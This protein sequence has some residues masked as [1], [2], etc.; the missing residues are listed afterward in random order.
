MS[1][2]AK[3]ADRKGLYS[4][5]SRVGLVRVGEEGREERDGLL[6]Y[7]QGRKGGRG[8]GEKKS[9]MSR[10]GGR[11]EVLASVGRLREKCC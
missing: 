5:T 6:M 11:A 10:S 9:R 8:R 7:W 1:A 2:V 4:N 3:A